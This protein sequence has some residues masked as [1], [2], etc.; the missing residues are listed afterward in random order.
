MIP[1]RPK[2]KPT[3]PSAGV[4][5]DAFVDR[6]DYRALLLLP[7]ASRAWAR[8]A[9]QVGPTLETRLAKDGFSEVFAWLCRNLPNVV[10][11]GG[12]SRRDVAG[13]ITLDFLNMFFEPGTVHAA[14]EHNQDAP[15]GA[16]K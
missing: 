7:V 2:R 11:K 5:W 3:S 16:M 8:Y 6:P 15:C 12:D 9:G 4:D 1:Y 10:F 14:L 13:E